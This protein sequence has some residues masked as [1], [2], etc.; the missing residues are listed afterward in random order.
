MSKIIELIIN[1]VNKFYYFKKINYFLKKLNIKIVIDVGS[2]KG[3]F[4]TS[5]ISDLKKIKKSILVE[6]QNNLIK[7]CFVWQIL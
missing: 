4:F 3:E 6:P 5:L 2:H 1:I 7:H